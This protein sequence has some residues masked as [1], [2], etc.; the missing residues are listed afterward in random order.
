MGE[1]RLAF[2]SVFSVRSIGRMVRSGDS[3]RF[4][5]DLGAAGHKIIEAISANAVA[6]AIVL[7]GFLRT[8]I[9]K[10]P[11]YSYVSYPE[12]LVLRTIAAYLARRFR[13]VPANRD[14]IVA[15]VIESMMDA[16]PYYVIR[17]DISSFYESIDADALRDRLLYN[18]S[19]PRSVRHYL[20][21]FFDALCP[22]G[23]QGLPRGV[24]L[25]TVLAELAME[26]FDQ[27]VRALQGVYR[28]F[29]YSD[30]IVIFAY[31]NVRDIEAQLVHLLPDGMHFN[32]KKQE[33]VDCAKKDQ[34][35]EKAFEYLGYR[36]STA[37][38]M[39]GDKPRVVDVTISTAKIKRL[40][41]RVI[42]TLKAFRK[43]GDGGLLLDRLRFLSSNYQINR[44]GASNW[45]HGKRVRSGI[46]YN[47]RRCGRYKA[48]EF[49]SVVPQSLAE[50]DNFT[51]GL[52]KSHVAS[53]R[54]PSRDTFCK[55]IAID[56]LAFL[57]GLDSF[58]V[59][60]SDSRTPASLS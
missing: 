11:C 21:L 20:G 34:G 24:G 6:R 42:L 57:F 30:D 29:R 40:K 45:I 52:L 44:H 26:K 28:Y 13:V 50:L 43:D 46:Y 32:P 49:E 19:L 2:Q 35:I 4:G 41:S 23:G 15:G 33:L 56:S 8:K 18:T 3:Q 1:G 5:Q 17:R 53:L 14:R 39:G 37:S 22:K 55:R 27:E 16:T 48:S 10:K 36:L 59:G 60:S 31:A 25:T 7:T 9:R 58:L 51:H 38:G 54:P 12:N 47:Y